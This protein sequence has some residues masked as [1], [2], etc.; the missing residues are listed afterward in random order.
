MSDT[1][2]PT[3]L[4]R[5]AGLQGLYLT[6]EDNLRLTTFGA[7]AGAEVAIEGRRITPD[8]RIVPFADR[9]VPNSDYTARTSLHALGEGLLTNVQLRATV[10]AAIAGHVFGVLEVVRGLTGGVQ[11]LATLLQGDITVNGR[12]AWPGSPIASPID[13]PGRLR[14]IVGTDPAANVEISEAVPAGRRWSLTSFFAT[15]VA[16]ANVA[17]RTVTLIVDDGANTIWQQDASAVQTAGQTRSYEAFNFGAAADLVGST[18]RLPAPFPISLPA[19]FRIRT[20]TANR[21]VGDNW[22]APTLL[23][24]EWIE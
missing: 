2:S 11:P 3:A 21:Q 18:F 14:S 9:H 24:E 22:S 20:S 1:Y 8:C 23:V 10:G 12:L 15:L 7:L 19:G 5:L 13:G 17:N 6:G 16:D 4:E